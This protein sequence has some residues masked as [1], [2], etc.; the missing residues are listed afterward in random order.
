VTPISFGVDDPAPPSITNAAV[1]I[2]NF[3]GVHLG[4]RRLIAVLRSEA[5]KLGVPAVVVCLYPHPAS[6]L[7]PDSAPATLLWPERRARLLAAA[8]ADRV[9]FLNVDPTLLALS[10][11]E[12]FERVLVGKLRVRALVEGENFRFGKARRGDV[13][14]LRRMCQDANV[15]MTAV[16]LVDDEGSAVSSTRIRVALA[17]GDVRVAAE[18]VGRRH[19][20]RGIVRAGAR[21]GRRIGFPTANLASVLGLIPAPGVYSAIARFDDDRSFSAA[22]NIGANPTFDEHAAKIEVHLLNFSEDVYGQAMEVEFVD[23][24]REVKMFKGPDDLVA[25]INADVERARTDVEAL[26]PQPIQSELAATIAEWVRWET[27]PSLAP[28]GVVLERA[29]LDEPGV[30]RLEWRFGAALPTHATFDLL[31]GLEERLREVFP[32]V[33]HVIAS[34]TPTH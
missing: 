12:F 24:I 16:P 27:S 11:E 14:L 10:P 17:V 34:T 19:C 8:G 20:I 4:H 22:C 5:R 30:V 18:M 29:R 28:L 9:A 21:R 1:A 15:S 2:G 23:R 32:E 7:R 25:Q 13:S 31:F 26:P 6:V 33:D 3:D